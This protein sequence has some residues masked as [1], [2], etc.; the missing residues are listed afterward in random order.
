MSEGNYW[1]VMTAPLL[2]CAEI[3][4]GAKLFYAQVSRFANSGGVC[5][6]SNPTLSAE[7]GVS[8]RTVT[9]YVAEL[10]NAGFICTEFVGVR[11][12][13][14]RSERHIRLAQPFPFK[15]DKNVY[16][17]LD[18]NV[19]DNIDKNVYP[20]KENNTR[21]KITPKAP[22]G[23]A[24]DADKN[25]EAER[26]MLFDRFWACYPRK[27]GKQAARRAWDRLKP[28]LLLCSQMSQALKIQMRSDEWRRD[29]GR[30]IPH[31]STWLNGRRW[32]DED[33]APSAPATATAPR[34]TAR[35]EDQWLT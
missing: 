32:E 25:A 3:S 18:K 6:K 7:L 23:G 31:P 5:W 33:V 16:L 19:E 20:H 2:E 28:D 26:A 21:K 35:E 15:V 30:Y 29:G 10:E 34:E 9:R 12:K 1:A 27:V 14:R 24:T 11:D 17:N 22:T 4:D 13:K 8:E